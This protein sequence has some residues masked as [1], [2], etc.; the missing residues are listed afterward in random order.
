M[1][2]IFDEVRNEGI[3]QG[4]ER[5]IEQGVVQSLRNLMKTQSIQIETAMEMLDLP[6]SD[7]EK[8]ERLLTSSDLET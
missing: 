8:Y 6:S 3:E 1:S 5:G 2:E 7:R 4:I